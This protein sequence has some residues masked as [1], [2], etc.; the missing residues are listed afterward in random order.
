MLANIAIL[1]LSGVFLIM[2][3]TF[4]PGWVAG[5]IGGLCILAAACLALLADDFDG[6]TSGQR[7]MLATG[8]L[9]TATALL[10]AW[11]RWFAVR[12]FRHRFTLLATVGRAENDEHLTGM[13]GV[14]LTELRPL[15]RAEIAGKRYDVRC[16]TGLAAV[17]TRVE[18]VTIEPG[19]LLV[20][21]VP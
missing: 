1:T 20:R 13:Q 14:A 18:V 2:L 3:E 4:L 6:W 21:T 11:L 15:G 16:Q 10:F 19:N 12:F 8:V 7:W 9:L 17:G 5:I